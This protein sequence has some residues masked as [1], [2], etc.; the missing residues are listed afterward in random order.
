M[1][2]PRMWPDPLPAPL[3]S[4]RFRQAEVKVYDLLRQQLDRHWTVF[5]SRPW[6]GLTPTGGEKDGECDFVAVHPEHGFL[7]IE[8]KGGGIS[9][10][11][12]TETWTSRD[13]DGIRHVIKNPVEQARKAKHGLL[14]LARQQRSWPRDRFVRARHGVIFPDAES[15]PGDLG[16]DRPRELF[17]CRPDLPRLAGWV[18][19]RLDGSDGE[20]PGRDGMRAIEKLLA[21]PFTLRVPLGHVLDDDE[22]QIGCLTPQQF[23]ILDA[24]ADLPRIAVG[25]GAGTGKTI[26]ATEDAARLAAAGRKTLLTCLGPELA[27]RLSER[28]AGSGVQVT[29]FPELCHRLAVQAGLRDEAA[30]P[31]SGDRAPELLLDALSA[32]PDLAFDAIVVDEAQDFPS[33]WWVAIEALLTDTGSS[34]LHAFYDTNQQVYGELRGRLAEYALVPIRLTHNLRNTRRIH[35]AAA[36][37][38]SGLPMTAHGPEGV[39]VQWLE[40]AEEAIAET[41]GNAIRSLCSREAVGAQDI[42]LLSPDDACLDAMLRQLDGSLPAGIV[43]ASVA[44]F[45]G[46]ESKVVVL[47]AARALS[48]QPELAYV[49]LSRARTHLVVAGNPAT[50]EWLGSSTAGNTRRKS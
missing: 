11:P 18:H 17:C 7:A 42:A 15:P 35:E 36:R 9:Y 20:G 33:H 47:A 4:D 45:K 23:H 32:R 10:D 3:R 24:L 48:D 2:G 29:T 5:Y 43:A 6:L 49:A 13:R 30:P 25:G 19:A 28:L 37:F 26:V 34:A 1:S 31:P 39:S 46:L 21:A 41:A 27:R 14:A 40:C 22:Q 12:I 50:L 44:G 38:Y 16:A 8:V